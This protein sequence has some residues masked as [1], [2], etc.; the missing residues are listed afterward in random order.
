MALLFYGIVALMKKY[1]IG[2]WSAVSIVIGCVI[3]SGVFVKPGR[4][5][6]AAGDSNHALMA[7]LLGG[8]ISLA[9]GLTIA[10]VAA[11]IPKNGGIYAY[12]EELYGKT[13]GFVCGWV[14][15]IIYGPA[16]MS[17][18]SLYF[19]SLFLQFFGLGD[20]SQKPVAFFVLFLLSAVSAVGTHYG[21]FISSLTTVLKLLPIALIGVC[22]LMMGNEPIFGQVFSSVGSNGEA[23]VAAGMGS[24]ILA[25]L[26]AYDGW[27]LVANLAGEIKDPAKNLP[28][29]IIYGLSGVIIAYLAV[30]A[31]L[32]HVLPTAQVAVL[33]ERA[34]GAATEVLFGTTGGK[35][36]SL[37]ILI[38]IFG[39]LNGSILTMTRVPF[40]MAVQQNFPFHNH[41]SRLH[42]RFITPVNAI[43]LKVFIAS[44]MIL[45]LNPDRITDIAMFSVY[46]FYA[47]VFAAIF[48]VRKI[49]GVPEKGN[50][51]I[52]L[53][54]I[55]PL[56]AF[57]GVVFVCGSMLVS[58]PLDAAA[59]LAVAALGFPVYY[60]AVK[61]QGEFK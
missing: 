37:G 8:L 14:Q 10:E 2:I 24:A 27:I 28:R 12:V 58:A 61:H 19:A 31:A 47:M 35:L 60:Y 32:F 22:G 25:T 1:Q 41:F 59:S 9:G 16:L 18:L 43:L 15:V 34:A 23:L 51:K 29:T 26:W 39:C 33:N 54:P 57:V 3:G 21:A 53:Y 6:L 13:W 5:L 45:F 36:L 56:F 44:V 50:Y 52:P 4:V 7:W 55:V 46:L 40:A 38:S 42:T 48:K 20:N 17:A 49:F 30:N 11:R